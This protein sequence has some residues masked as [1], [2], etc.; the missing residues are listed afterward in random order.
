MY[1]CYCAVNKEVIV[2]LLIDVTTTLLILEALAVNVTSI[3]KD[4]SMHI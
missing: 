1:L 2:L 3:D 4:K